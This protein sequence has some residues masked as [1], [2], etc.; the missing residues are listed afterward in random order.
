MRR[1]TESPSSPG[2]PLIRVVIQIPCYNEEE[3]LPVTLGELPRALEGVDRVEWLIIDDGSTDR[4]VEVARA[5]GV[6]HVV[7]LPAHQG[8]A[9]GFAAGLAASLAAGADIVVNT[10][11]DNQY[12]AGD[13]Q[14]LIDPI[15]RGEAEL[16]VGE[17]PID[18]IP[19]FSRTKRL[20]QRLGSW[21][22][23][24]ASRTS[25]PDAPSGFRAM[26][27]SAATRLNVYND[28]SY[29][30]ETII[31]A[32]HKG[33]AVTSVPIRTNP[34][35]RP[36]RLVRSNLHYILRQGL[37]IVRIFM[38]YRPFAFFAVPGA[39][40]FAG[41]VLGGLRFL[42][43]YLSGDGSGHVQ[44]LI[45]SALLLGIGFFLI[46]VGLLADLSAVN[47]K[48]LESVDG[49]LQ[50]MEYRARRGSE[51]VEGPPA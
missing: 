1:E 43:F 25:V 21:T 32:G 51:H 22:V 37:T 44:S 45:L 17:R 16:V 36:S 31:Q 46:V 40:V 29:V 28:F 7:S 49:R 20:L 23:R 10:D 18:A 24:L 42:W 33:I 8:L 48:L 2:T 15:L 13:I 50:E 39:V 34:D 26:S 14:K 30:L 47:R 38:T 11:A 5:H 12:H 9:R 19:H 41:G 4:T 6:D 27:R 3:A 35:L